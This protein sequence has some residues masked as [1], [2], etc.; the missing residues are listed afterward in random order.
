MKPFNFKLTAAMAVVAFLAAF[1]P[2][3]SAFA[4]T[5]PIADQPLFTQSAQ[6]PLMMMVMSRDEQLFNKAY[7]DYSDLDGDGVLDTTYQDRFDYSGYFDPALCYTYGSGQFSASAKAT[8]TVAAG[9]K[10]PHQCTGAYSGN[11]M[12]WVSMSRL[13]VLNFVFSG[14]KRV[15]P[16]ASNGA[17]LER[18]PIPPDLHAWVKVYSGS[19]IAKFTP[20]TSTTSFCNAT[21]TSGAA[22]TIRTAKGAY[23][24]WAATALQMCNWREE[25]YS[26]GSGS[27]SGAAG[28]NSCYDD[29]PKSDALNTDAGLTARVQ[30]CTN[31]DATKRE[32]FCQK[33]TNSS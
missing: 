11:F 5:I 7:D 6:P 25:V 19:D 17:V 32:S 31:S 22:P 4:A 3:G 10:Y 28:D 23:P 21:M 15:T 33:Y 26:A 27:C 12:N 14:G 20:Y 16:E 30:V 1:D 18:A 2:A 9:Q 29:P 8:G 24:E 13:D